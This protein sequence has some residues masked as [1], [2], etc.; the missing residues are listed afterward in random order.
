MCTGIENLIR[1]TEQ[2][3][4]DNSIDSITYRQWM[5]A[6]RPS[7]KTTVQ[8]CSNFLKSFDEKLI[9]LLHH[10]FI[11]QQQS[12]FCEELKLKLKTGEI[13]VICDFPKNYCIVQDFHWSNAPSIYGL[14]F[15]K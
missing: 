2:R 14:L 5:T 6:D 3:F 7:L 10:S 1:N 4:E 13:S 11:A 8:S 15:G 9:I 12:S